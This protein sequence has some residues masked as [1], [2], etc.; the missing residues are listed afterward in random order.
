MMRPGAP[1]APQPFRAVGVREG[2]LLFAPKE[3]I[4]LFGRNARLDELAVI[5]GQV[6]ESI[7][8]Q[9]ALRVVIELLQRYIEVEG[10]GDTSGEGG[11]GDVHI[12]R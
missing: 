2:L 8:Q 1:L 12:S 6:R 11:A 5:S 4:P 10:A 3:R 9:R 7:L